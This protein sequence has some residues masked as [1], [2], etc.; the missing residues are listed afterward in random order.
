MHAL[1]ADRG[2]QRG[3]SALARLGQQ[4]GLLP[5]QP[6]ESCC[7]RAVCN[8]GFYLKRVTLIGDVLRQPVGASAQ[9]RRH[10]TL[11]HAHT[12]ATAPSKANYRLPRPL[13][14]RSRHLGTARARAR[15]IY[16]AFCCVVLHVEADP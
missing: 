13:G 7:Y 16:A 11:T 9:G 3:P 5:Y 14:N 1:G 12:H 15:R 10:H 8:L 2:Y 4:V 6:E